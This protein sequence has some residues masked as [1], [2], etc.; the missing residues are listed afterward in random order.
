[1][2]E[3]KACRSR[4]DDPSGRNVQRHGTGRSTVKIGQY[5]GAHVHLLVGASQGHDRLR[6]AEGHANSGQHREHTLLIA[7]RSVRFE[8]DNGRSKFDGLAVDFEMRDRRQWWFGGWPIDLRRICNGIPGVLNRPAGEVRTCERRIRWY[9]DAERRRQR[10][11]R[12]ELAGRGTS[13]RISGGCITAL[14]W[15]GAGL[16]SPRRPV[17]TAGEAD[18]HV[19][20]IDSA[21]IGECGA[22]LE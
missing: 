15:R 8:P 12:A 13:V 3:L 6:G 21:A 4:L 17:S 20:E 11:V 5:L 9:G 7:I 10:R 2:G 19:G 14:A 1:M 16:L 22:N 18:L